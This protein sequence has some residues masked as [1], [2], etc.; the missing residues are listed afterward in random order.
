MNHT[1]SSPKDRKTSLI[2]A[3]R[4]SLINPQPSPTRWKQW[5]GKPYC[6]SSVKTCHI[7]A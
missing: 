7:P 3:D 6:L 2:Q 5:Y 1:E 4:R